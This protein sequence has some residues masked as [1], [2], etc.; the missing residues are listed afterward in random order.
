MNAPAVEWPAMLPLP[1]LPAS[2]SSGSRPSR[3]GAHGP[4]RRRWLRIASV[5]SAAA[6]LSTVAAVAEPWDPDATRVSWLAP[7]RTPAVAP[8]SAAMLAPFRG[9][10]TWIDVYDW[11]K[12]Y[13][14]TA[15][16]LSDIDKVA[17][18]GYQTIYVQTTKSGH[19]D[20]V[21][22]PARLKAIIN[23]AHLR[24]LSVVGWYLPSHDDEMRDYRKTIAM[25]RLGVDG[26]G[27][28]LESTVVKDV[29][30]RSA[31]AVR[32]MRRVTAKLKSTGTKMG[33]A[34]ITYTP[35]TLESSTRLWPDFPWTALAP[36]TTVW[37]P[38]SYWSQQIKRR[39]GYN[40]AAKF[41]D[42]TITRLRQLLGDS[43]R[44][45]LIGGS[46]MSSTQVTKMVSVAMAAGGNLIGSSLYDWR[47]TSAAAHP[48]MLPLRT[49][50]TSL[51]QAASD[52][53]AA[54]D[55]VAYRNT[56]S[57]ITVSRVR[58]DGST[59]DTHTVMGPAA[60]TPTAAVDNGPRRNRWFIA[61]PL[62]GGVG[63]AWGGLSSAAAK[64][65]A[66]PKAPRVCAPAASRW[67]HTG[68]LLLCRGVTTVSFAVSGS[69]GGNWSTW[70]RV[71]L[72]EPAA[73]LAA[74]PLGSQVV[75]VWRTAS[76]AVR[77]ALWDPAIPT[78]LA[79][80]DVVTSA[81]EPVRATAPLR[82]NTWIRDGSD[83]A[84]AVQ[85]SVRTSAGVVRVAL[86]RDGLRTGPVT[87]PAAVADSAAGPVTDA[88]VDAGAWVRARNTNGTI[89]YTH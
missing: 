80:V 45:H 6:M 56:G 38:M 37:M 1:P 65:T 59:W 43:A 84:S 69:T 53:V 76:D 86:D 71:P 58:A 21:L 15:F 10:G 54:S 64:L 18:A 46:G 25:L 30:K 36:Y 39:N 81:G 12:R 5:V 34:S 62:A 26:I 75:L 72:A 60:G 47:T 16:R 73:D 78:S 24:G 20:L 79:A 23:R 74:A 33:V 17:A 3:L 8:A 2:P 68:F 41:S 7:S 88:F 87:A 67:S 49:L 19:P 42:A 51:P 22:E 40:D 27:L 66:V 14:G 31:A 4:A 13:G 89:A 44:I 32:L 82:V 29:P 28:D 63:A 50:R 48:K 70:K 85:L 35:Y 83:T 77:A 9:S 57:S 61:A 55:L 52:P 11:S